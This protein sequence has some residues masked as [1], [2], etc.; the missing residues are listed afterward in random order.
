MLFLCSLLLAA[1]F[2]FIP[3]L[4]VE[5][6]K[7]IH[8]CYADCEKH[9][10]DLTVVFPDYGPYEYSYGQYTFAYNCRG[11]S[12][13]FCPE[14][15]DFTP[16]LCYTDGSYDIAMASIDSMSLHLVSNDEYIVVYGGGQLTLNFTTFGHTGDLHVYDEY[17]ISLHIQFYDIGI[18]P[19]DNSAT[20]EIVLGSVFGGLIILIIC[21]C[22]TVCVTMKRRRDSERQNLIS[23]N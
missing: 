6:C 18:Q 4:S 11:V 17:Q 8:P 19:K 3:V 5:S 21:C 12:I 7:M 14:N 13:G 10:V 1:A 22:V 20:L 23:E 9:T 16:A 2:Q 15:L